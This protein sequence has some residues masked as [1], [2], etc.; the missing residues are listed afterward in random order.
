LTSTNAKSNDL[1]PEATPDLQ[2]S[3]DGLSNTEQIAETNPEPKDPKPCD[4]EDIIQTAQALKKL[5]KQQPQKP[6]KKW[7]KILFW[8]IFALFNIGVLLYT[9]LSDF[10]GTRDELVTSTIYAML[11]RH[12]WWLFIAIAAMFAWFLCRVVSY[13]IKVHFF[14]G[15]K[16]LKLC[17]C[18]IMIGQFYDKTTPLGAG[19]KPL[20]MHYLQK[21]GI[22]EGAAI[23]MPVIDYVIGR[24]TF[25][26][27]S[28]SAIILNALNVFGSNIVMDIGIYVMAILGVA[29]NIGLPTLLLVSLVS[30]RASRKITRFCVIVAKR[31]RLTKDPVRMY[32]KTIMKLDANI[33]CMKLLAK[34]KR[35]LLCVIL[36][37]ASKLALAS[38]G[39]FVIKAFGFY[40]IHGWGWAEI[41]VLN[42]LIANSV[43]FIPTPGNSGAADLSFYW[44]YSSFL[45]ASTGV[46]SGALATLLWRF[47]YYYMPVLIGLIFVVVIARQKKKEQLQDS[48]NNQEI[49]EAEPDQVLTCAE[50]AACD[51]EPKEI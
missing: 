38:V 13:S 24:L 41:V 21:N 4:I 8:T 17:A 33:K 3:M 15:K 14:T 22:P 44:V 12:W 42:L 37:I 18:A 34:R 7:K 36:S 10:L 31:L 16:R 2:E 43:S 46:A 29:L 51:C 20:Q 30:K 48:Q 45:L 35:L 11:R 39:Y 49:K 19:S 50:T 32:K 47:I 28:I 1:E 5:K 27:L 26:L 23:T 25:V 6:K 9:M 40:T